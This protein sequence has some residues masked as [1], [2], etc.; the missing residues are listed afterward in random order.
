MFE[1]AELGHRIDKSSYQEEVPRLRAELL[2]AQKG[3]AVSPFSVLIMVAG[4]P[5]AGKSETVDRLLEW[6][7]PR[8]V[9][10]HALSSP[11]DEERVRPP[12]WRFWRRIPPHGRIGIFY[13]GWDIRP[14]VQGVFGRIDQL[15]ME[16]RL[17]GFIE[18][19]RMLAREKVLLIKLWL[20]LSRPALKKRL[21]K[22]QADPEQSWRIAR[23]D[24]KLFRRYDL[25]R[26]LSEHMI[27]RTSMGEAPWTIIEASDRRYRDLT[28]AR[29]VLTAIQERLEGLKNAPARPE[30]KPL[31]LEPAPRNVIN[32]LDLSR[33]LDPRDFKQEIKLAAGRLGFLTRSL[34]SKKR[35]LI[36]VFEGPD[37]AGKGGTIRRLTRA[38]DARDYQVISVAAPTDEEKAHPYLWRFWR[39][40]P[41]LGQ[42]TIYDRSWYGRVLVERVEGFATSEEW[43]RAYAE[44]N[45]FEAQLVDSHILVL[46]F[47]LAISPEE[48][49]RRFKD[50]EV[51]PYKQYKITQEDW[52]NRGKWNSYEAAACD[53]IER[54]STEHAPWV[55]VEAENKEY[56]RLKVMTTVI[57]KLEKALGK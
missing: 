29:T 6:L 1:N 18:F 38:M 37:A 31:T 52:R 35:S 13:G 50:R 8:G 48:Q 15:H 53:M 40:L 27:R 16:R 19:E 20:H 12:L 24:W 4:V 56:G 42:V 54:T 33:K 28:S 32:T 45:Q 23:Q 39:H 41:P 9:Q 7:D 30:T 57:E 51:T 34:H 55:L 10:T 22:L 26:S 3:L 46:K 49:L 43:Q 2:E 36:L 5:A 47:W 11:T 21:K 44:I 14:L 17:D 25:Y